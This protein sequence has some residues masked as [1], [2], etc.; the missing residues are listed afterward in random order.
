MRLV[1]QGE[2]THLPPWCWWLK[3]SRV[4]TMLDVAV[5]LMA[6]LSVLL[7]VISWCTYAQILP[8]PTHS[9]SLLLFVVCHTQFMSFISN[10]T[11]RMTRHI[12]TKIW[13]IA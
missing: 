8:A 9:S 10:V 12:A 1:V 7:L 6:V 13:Q 2:G 4:V 3:W 11:S 5:V